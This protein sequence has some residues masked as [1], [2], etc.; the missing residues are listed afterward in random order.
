MIRT[1]HLTLGYADR[2]L[3]DDLSI[4]AGGGQLIGLLGR[5][6]VGKSTLLRAMAGVL[7]PLS[8]TVLVGSRP[9]GSLTPAER[10]ERVSFVSTEN[11]SVAHLRVSEV[12]EM[13]RAPYTGWLGTLSAQERALADQA[14]D[15]VGMLPFR[16]KELRTLSDGERGRVMIARALTQDTPVMLLDEPTAFLDIPN[17]FQIALLLRELAHDTGK[18]ILFSSHDLSTALQLCDTLWVAS[19]RGVAAGPVAEVVASGAL[20]VIFEGTSLRLEGTEVRY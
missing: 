17:R 11:H 6:G 2:L 16:N 1:E 5:N 18:T 10:A 9:I 20:E 13:G 19:H 15:R 14:L 4:S 12:V 3:I 7:K 8:G